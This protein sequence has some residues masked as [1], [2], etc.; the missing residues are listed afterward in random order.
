MLTFKLIHSKLTRFSRVTNIIL[1]IL[2]I[3]LM[4]SVFTWDYEKSNNFVAIIILSI[5]LGIFFFRLFRSFIIKDFKIIGT[6]T[7]SDKLILIGSNSTHKSFEIKDIHELGFTY[8]GYEGESFPYS[9]V[10]SLSNFNQKQGNKNLVFFKNQNTD[11]EFE[12]HLESNSH[13]SL[14][15]RYL[16]EIENT[17]IIFMFHNVFGKNDIYKTY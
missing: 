8:Y 14:L 7:L 16:R 12:F 11:Y 1:I 9:Y 2:F 13:R 15:F 6:L 4:V 17:G 3:V 10:R 5:Y